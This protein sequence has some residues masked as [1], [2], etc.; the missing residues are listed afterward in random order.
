MHK[1]TK[2]ECDICHCEFE[3]EAEAVECEQ[4]NRF[5]KTVRL[6][7]HKANASYTQGGR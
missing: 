3:T 7:N 4:H 2:Y 6:S 1:I 5:P